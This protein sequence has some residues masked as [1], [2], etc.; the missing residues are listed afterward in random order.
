MKQIRIHINPQY[1][2]TR[3]MCHNNIDGITFLYR[4]RRFL[5]SNGK[6]PAIRTN[7]TTPQDH[8]SAFAPSYPLSTITWKYTA[9]QH[10]Q[11]KYKKKL[12]EF[13]ETDLCSFLYLWCNIIGCTTSSMQQSIFLVKNHISVK[14]VHTWITRLVTRHYWE[15][16]FTKRCTHQTKEI[17]LH[18]ICTKVKLVIRFVM[19]MLIIDLIFHTIFIF[20]LTLHCCGKALRPKSEIFKFPL[21]SKSRFSGCRQKEK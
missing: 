17:L 15:N 21:E 14:N 20:G 6:Y 8:R 7:R 16:T 12:H 4:L 10:I 1:S 3:N 13:P 5:S 18:L 2:K 19:G 9:L 11:S